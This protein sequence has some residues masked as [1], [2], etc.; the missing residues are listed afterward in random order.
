MLITECRVR[1]VSGDPVRGIAAI[2]LDDQFVVKGIRILSIKGRL[3]V[4]MP[5]RLGP[6]GVHRDVAHP[7]NADSR[8]KIDDQI[9]ASYREVVMTEAELPEA[10]DRQR[11]VAALEIGADH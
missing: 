6:D 5:S 11:E 7:I 4:C 3:L 1:L 2:T 8:R 10:E 9:L